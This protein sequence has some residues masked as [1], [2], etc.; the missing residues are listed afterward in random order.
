MRNSTRLSLLLAPLVA[1]CVSATDQ[2]KPAR[3]YVDYR[4]VVIERI[5]LAMSEENARAPGPVKFAYESC[6]ADTLLAQLTSQQKGRLDAWARGERTLTAGE[7]RDMDAMIR[8]KMGTPE[9]SEGVYKAME[10]FCP[11]AVPLF[12]QHFKPA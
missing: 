2:V 10:P 3:Y 6:A 4:A 8:E 1:G 7:M 5:D 12:R 9:T 11:D